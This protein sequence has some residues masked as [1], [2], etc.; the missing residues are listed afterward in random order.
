MKYQLTCLPG[1]KVP[2]VASRKSSNTPS[3]S[4]QSAQLRQSEELPKRCAD[5]LKHRRLM[6]RRKMVAY[7]VF[8]LARGKHCSLHRCNLALPVR[9][10][11]V[12]LL[13]YFLRIHLLGHL[14]KSWNFME[15]SFFTTSHKPNINE[16]SQKLLR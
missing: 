11:D 14:K 6:I 5:C 9:C 1:Q 16:R 7:L 2:V 13:S 15:S 3:Q 8:S 10:P 4:S 12:R